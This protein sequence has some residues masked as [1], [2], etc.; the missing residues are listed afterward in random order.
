ME[1][2]ANKKRTNT[3]EMTSRTRAQ[4]TGRITGWKNCID[5]VK[6]CSRHNR[7]NDDEHEDGRRHQT[8]DA[9]RK[10][11][12]V[13]DIIQGKA[14]VAEASR[15]YDLSPSEVEQ[16]GDDGKRGMENALRANPQNVREQYERQLKDPQEAYAEAM[17]ELRARKKLQS[18]LGEDEK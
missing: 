12:L 7:G 1:V 10:S 4:G 13:L 5:P 14:T 9:K 17:R 2:L 16:W 18:L 6:S 8:P 3:Q 15:Q 11:A